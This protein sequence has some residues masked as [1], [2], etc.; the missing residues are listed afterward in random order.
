MSVKTKLHE[1]LWIFFE[2]FK[3]GADSGAIMLEEEEQI[4]K[5]TLQAN[6]TTQL[7]TASES[8]G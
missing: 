3:D 5:T 6:G 4:L 8:S 1:S 2:I 7:D